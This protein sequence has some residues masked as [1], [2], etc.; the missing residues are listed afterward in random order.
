[1]FRRSIPVGR[2]FGILVDLDYSWFLV[3][4]LL[5]WVMAVS[6]YPAEYHNWSTGEYWF[7]GFLTALAL[8]V[9]VLLHELGH[10]MV[11]KHFGLDVPRITL[12]I[13]GGVSQISE[14]PP[15]AAAEFWIAVV[16]PVVSFALAAFFWEIGPLLAGVP[17]LFALAKY[18]ALLNLIL[19]VFNL[20][21]GFPLDG[22]R[23]FRAIVWRITGKYTRAT[24][25]ASLSGRFMGFCLIF[26]G[27]WQAL[28]GNLIGG[29]WTAFIGW[30][31]ESAA[32]SV[33]QQELLRSLLGEHKVTDAMQKEFPRVPG[34]VT[35][36]ELVEGHILVTGRRYFVVQGANG[37]PG[38]LTLSNIRKVP[39]GEWAT[40]KASQVML[41]LH[42]LDTT[43]PDA[44]LWNALQK[45]G[46]DGVNQMPV[47][48]GSGIVGIL[49]R[50]DI[51]HYL[52]VLE[53][54]AR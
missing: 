26:F 6:Y 34:E 47:V 11:A 50:E 51:L 28:S 1:M 7:M 18:L 53:A 27:V 5:T 4:A 10:S 16:G 37:E 54:V 43:P 21:P 44:V 48:Q 42:K 52:R 39:R 15:N 35:L 33:M 12:F 32:G 38:L 2:I 46:R 40:T 41:P 49:S 25:I 19:G 30:F 14:E 3:L 45:M 36:Q 23:V 24:A 22:G 17:P 29:M 13:F 9:S 8:F 31:L 20:I